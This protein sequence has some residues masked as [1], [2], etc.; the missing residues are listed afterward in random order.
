LYLFFWGSLNVVNIVSKNDDHL[1]I[2]YVA[3][4]NDALLREG[5][6]TLSHIL[7]ALCERGDDYLIACRGAEGDEAEMIQVEIHQR[8]HGFQIELCACQNM[9]SEHGDQNDLDLYVS[10]LND[11]KH[12]TENPDK[13][14]ENPALL[15]WEWLNNSCPCSSTSL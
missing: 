7:K 15:D 11:L 14:L 3:L 13:Y 12:M 5:H 6:R 2:R 1:L 4:C 9:A 10:P 8:D